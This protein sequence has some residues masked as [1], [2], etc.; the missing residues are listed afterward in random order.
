MLQYRAATTQ[1]MTDGGT[2][3]AERFTIGFIHADKAVL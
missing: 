1:A 3:D 2:G